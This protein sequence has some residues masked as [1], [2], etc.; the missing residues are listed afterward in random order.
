[1]E[2]ARARTY[3]VALGGGASVYH[4]VNAPPLPRQSVGL[5]TV[6]RLHVPDAVA[7]GAL[8]AHNTGL[9]TTAGPSS[10]A[11]NSER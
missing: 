8:N 1:M 7:G 6:D 2:E 11:V 3:H 4:N 5:Q 10:T 9:D